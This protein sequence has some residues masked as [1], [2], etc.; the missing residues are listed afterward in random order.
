M[1][2]TGNNIRPKSDQASRSLEARLTADRPDPENRPFVHP[3][4]I[5]WTL[6]HRGEILRALYVILLGNPQLRP[7][8]RREA[9][10]RFKAWWWLV[11]SAVEHAAERVGQIVSFKAM[12]E[13]VEDNDDEAAARG[14]ILQTLYAIKWP[15]DQAK[16]EG[17]EFPEFTCSNLL[18][19]FEESTKNAEQDG[20]PEDVGTTEL[21]RFCTPKNAKAV[22]P[23]SISDALKAIVDSPVSVL[24]GTA[25]LRR[26]QD[27]HSKKQV[28]W[29]ELKQDGDT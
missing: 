17:A 9:Q 22:S 23:K 16:K 13:R 8:C 25:S 28:F 14:D 1:G 18:A 12:F 10:T 26:R 2:F 24:A 7:E 15:P 27:T 19:H 21:R 29:V 4:P 3:D 20:Q 11:G 5:G 6:D